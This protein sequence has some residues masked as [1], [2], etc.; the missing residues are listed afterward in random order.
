MLQSLKQ[1]PIDLT[2]VIFM[3]DQ[4]QV[5]TPELSYPDGK[6]LVVDSRYDLAMGDC[7]RYLESSVLSFDTILSVT[8][9]PGVHNTDVTSQLS[10]FCQ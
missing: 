8:S 2:L 5:T 9:S 7:L 1:Y 10:R 3:G 4:Q 6:E